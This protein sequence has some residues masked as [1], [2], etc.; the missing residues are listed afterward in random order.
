MG[1]IRRFCSDCSGQAVVEAAFAL[2]VMMV[3]MLML[4]QPA[5]VLYDRAV[6]NAAAAEGCRLLATARADE[7]EACEGYILRRLGSVPQQD[8]FHVHEPSCAWEVDLV[9]NSSS[10]EVTVRIANEVRLLPLI[11]AGATA[12]GAAEGEG[13]MRIEVEATLPT[14]PSWISGS[15]VGYESAEWVGAWIN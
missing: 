3:L 10:A 1:V 6:M 11:G 9:G 8:L 15:E 5:I 2:P 14:Q 12:L 13:R 7:V 4:V